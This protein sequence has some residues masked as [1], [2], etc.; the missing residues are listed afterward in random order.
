AGALADALKSVS[1]LEINPLL[2]ALQAQPSEA[3]GLQTLASL[4]SARSLSSVR[5]DLLKTWLEKYPAP[6][7]ASGAALMNALNIDGAKQKAHFETLAQTLTS[8]DVR[9]GQALFNSAKA[10]CATCHTM[11]YLGG[12]VGP[13]LTRIGEVRTSR[14]LLESIVYPNASFVRSFE[15]SVVT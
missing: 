7:Q 1:P 13:D 9:R 5:Y 12:K 8:G 14:D 6:V 3:L 11:G 2:E 10:A 4:R 15:P